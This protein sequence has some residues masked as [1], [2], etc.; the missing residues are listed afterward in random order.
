MHS[1]IPKILSA[2]LPLAVA[3]APDPV[4]P[5]RS[6]PPDDQN[7]RF[8]PWMACSKSEYA[9]LMA[10]LHDESEDE[11]SL[12]FAADE[13]LDA[14]CY[15]K[16][17][18]PPETLHGWMIATLEASGDGDAVHI[19]LATA[20]LPEVLSRCFAEEL[21]KVHAKVKS[22][23]PSVEM[24]RQYGRPRAFDTDADLERWYA[25]FGQERRLERGR[26]RTTPL[27]SPQEKER[28]VVLAPNRYRMKRCLE[29]AEVRAPE[30]GGGITHVHVTVPVSG[31]NVAEV[32]CATAPQALAECLRDAM[33]QVDFPREA[34]SVTFDVPIVLELRQ[35]VRPNPA[36][37]SSR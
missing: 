7:E 30:L 1:R 25:S 2:L 4:A 19:V 28:D 12:A 13:R 27:V 8:A 21:L 5:S 15:A 18:L 20:G 24:A 34:A 31:P 22:A 11:N 37:P 35:H 6:A 23:K 29:E 3:C 10:R 9:A 32:G 17:G 26:A 33:V 36:A 16:L 14:G